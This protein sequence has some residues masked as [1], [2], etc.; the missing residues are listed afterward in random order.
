MN[1]PLLW[2]CS[3]YDKWVRGFRQRNSFQ[4]LTKL[5]QQDIWTTILSQC[6]NTRFHVSGRFKVQRCLSSETREQESWG[7]AS[8][9]WIQMCCDQT[10]SVPGSSLTFYLSSSWVFLDSND[11]NT[12]LF[13]QVENLENY[14]ERKNKLTNLQ[15]E[16][17]DS[18][19][20][21]LKKTPKPIIKDVLKV[22]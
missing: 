12:F 8:F 19:L 2:S 7:M 11:K 21:I 9:I 14:S 3:E 4:I 5:S 1:K 18:V 15:S 17:Q 22:I 6:L 20:E 16:T 10:E 13:F